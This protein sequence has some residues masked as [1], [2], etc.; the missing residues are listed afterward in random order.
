MCISICIYR[1]I[2][3][4]CPPARSGPVSGPVPGNNNDSNDDNNYNNN[5]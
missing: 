1:D 5:N 2:Y 3:I 4:E